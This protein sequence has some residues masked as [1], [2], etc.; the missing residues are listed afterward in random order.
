MI[1]LVGDLNLPNLDWI[2][3]VPLS[4]ETIYWNAHKLL[5]NASLTQVIG[6]PT[7]NNS[8]LDLLLTTAPDLIDDS[9]SYQDVVDSDHNCI[10]FKIGHSPNNSRPV[11]KEVFNYKKANFGELKRSLSYVPWHVAMLDDDLNS[12]VSNWE[13]LL[14]AAVDDFVPKKKI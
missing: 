3:Q 14:W 10:S 7:R 11:L 4:L 6:Y 2:N 8:I 5:N 13:D 12:I 1:F 9:Y